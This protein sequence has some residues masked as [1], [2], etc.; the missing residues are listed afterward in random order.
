MSARGNP[1]LSRESQIDMDS[2]PPLYAATSTASLY[3]PEL[4][5]FISLCRKLSAHYT[6][7]HAGGGGR[8]VRSAPNG[9]GKWP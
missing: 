4:Q 5:P 9:C 7:S 3:L 1:R 2:M 8:P 6:L